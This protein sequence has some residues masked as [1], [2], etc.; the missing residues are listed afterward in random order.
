MFSNFCHISIMPACSKDLEV[1]GVWQGT[2]L[3]EK[4]YSGAGIE[5][6]VS[7]HIDGGSQAL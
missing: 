7:P 1:W 6:V 4:C 5:P 3:A 2:V